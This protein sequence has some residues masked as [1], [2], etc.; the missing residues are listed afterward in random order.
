MTVDVAM[1]RGAWITGRVVDASTGEG[2][3]ADVNYFTFEDNPHL[4]TDGRVSWETS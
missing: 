1:R 4:D 3:G 2:V